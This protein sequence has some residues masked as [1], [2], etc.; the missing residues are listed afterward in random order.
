MTGWRLGWMVHPKRLA[1]PMAVLAEVSNTGATAFA[2]YG[3]IAALREGEGF[4]A[5]FRERCRSTG[6]S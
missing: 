6:T 2:Q 1:V 3:G 5:E 4:V